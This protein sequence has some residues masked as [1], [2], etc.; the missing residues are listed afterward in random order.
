M[1]NDNNN[2]LAGVRKDSAKSAG[3]LILL[4]TEQMTWSILGHKLRH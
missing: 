1:I 4:S 2:N 3:H